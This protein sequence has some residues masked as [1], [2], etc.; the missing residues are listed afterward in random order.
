MSDGRK[1][2][3]ICEDDCKFE[4]MTTEQILAAIAQAAETG[5]VFDADAAF[6]TKVKEGNAGGYL[7][8][9]LGTQAQYNAIVAQGKKDPKCFYILTDCD[10]PADLTQK[11]K[12]LQNDIANLTAADVGAAPAGYGIGTASKKIT[13][14]INNAVVGGVYYYE[15]G[16]KNLPVD[17]GRGTIFVERYGTAEVFQRLKDVRGRKVERHG[18]LENGMWVFDPPEYVNPPLFMGYAKYADDK[19][20]VISTEYRTTKRWNGKPVYI[21]AFDFGALPYN[22]K[23]VMRIEALNLDKVID[24]RVNIYSNATLEIQ[25]STAPYDKSS[26]EIVAGS[27]VTFHTDSE[28]LFQISTAWD[29]RHY[30]ALV[31]V[32]YI[33]D[34]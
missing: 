11:V 23:K 1:Y 32:E 20:K 34:E 19:Y 27:L 21:K 18:K 4:T 10:S 17:I 7:T 26:G 24:Y 13:D 5:L 15:A 29:M 12:D 31:Y 30:N 28:F 9:W 2:F 33:K 8:F 3:C 22:S 6:I 14:D 25:S 16:V